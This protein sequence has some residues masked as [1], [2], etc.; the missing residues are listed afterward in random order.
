MAK[1]PNGRSSIDRRKRGSVHLPSLWSGALSIF[2]L[3]LIG[4]I[5]LF[6]DQLY[7]FPPNPQLNALPKDAVVICLAGGKFRVEAAYSLYAQGIGQQLWI[8]GAG[9]KSTAIGLAKAHADEVV[10]KLSPEKF[11]KI[12]V[13]T[14]SRN[15]IENAIAVA[16]LLQKNPDVKSVI[17]ITSGYHMRRAQVMIE[18]LVER[19]ITIT[20]FIPPTEAIGRQNWWHTWVGIEVTTWEYFKF[21]LTS[22]LAPKLDSF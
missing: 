9:K 6:G 13:E 3:L 19:G 11:E 21:L 14:E 20:P 22:L 7:S 12:Q 15:T 1:Q 18:N 4:G 8:V 2:L 16:R 17:L 5:R 10:P